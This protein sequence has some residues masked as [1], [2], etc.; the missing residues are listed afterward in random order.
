MT[1]HDQTAPETGLS[2][3][4][5]DRGGSAQ[6]AATVDLT[7]ARAAARQ[8]DSASRVDL[9]AIDD[10]DDREVAR[11]AIFDAEAA[12]ARLLAPTLAEVD[13]QAIRVAELERYHYSLGQKLATAL[14]DCGIP[15]TGGSLEGDLAQLAGYARDGKRVAELERELA[16]AREVIESHQ[17]ERGRI[18][19]AL[20]ALP[21]MLDQL[22]DIHAGVRALRAR[23][24]IAVIADNALTDMQALVEQLAQRDEPQ[25][26]PRADAE[27]HGNLIDDL[28]RAIEHLDGCAHAHGHAVAVMGLGVDVDHAE[29]LGRLEHAR[30]EVGRL[31]GALEAVL[32]SPPPRAGDERR[33]PLCDLQIGDEIHRY[34]RWQRITEIAIDGD[35]RRITTEHDGPV[36]APDDVQFLARR[37][38][39]SHNGPIAD[40]AGEG[41]AGK[42]NSEP[43]PKP[44]CP[45]C[46]S[47]RWVAASLDE[48]YTRR[49]QCVPC[50]A[51]WPGVISDPKCVP[52]RQPAPAIDL[53]AALKASVER[54]KAKRAERQE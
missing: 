46:G 9:K 49:R 6:G 28:R 23:P 48:G 30:T 22:A 24:H 19:E 54:A 42:G 53:M 10:D 31:L 26:E 51:I 50:G 25:P 41:V 37:P 20:R 33:T 17:A 13:R 40:T 34:G 45:K 5:E 29:R 27:A 32:G 35:G 8:Y 38:D 47:P 7:E 43:E 3:T 12:A 21:T 15:T 1:D 39:M 52:W 11:D 36:W 2:A 14:A 44:G 18:G 4:Q 16:E